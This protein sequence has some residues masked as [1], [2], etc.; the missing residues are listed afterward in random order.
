MSLSRAFARGAAAAAFAVALAA[1]G[2]S[3]SLAEGDQPAPN[4]LGGQVFPNPAPLGA[5]VPRADILE[6]MVKSA[7]MTFNDANLT[8]NYGLLNERMHVEFRQQAPPDRLASIF[9]AFR[10]NKID[11]APLLAHKLVYEEPPTID[12]NGLLVAKGYLETRPWRTSFDL[13]WRRA[14]DLWWLWRINVRVRPP[15]Q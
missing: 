15:D 5:G 8:G 7:L 13:A 10:S 6:V 11:I 4:E 14:G 1:A 3:A 9:A 2:V 12:P